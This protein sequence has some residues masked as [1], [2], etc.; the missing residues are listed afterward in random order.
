MNAPAAPSAPSRIRSARFRA[1]READWRRLEEIVTK[2]ERRG[3]R[4]LSF[5][6]AHD[7]ATLYRQAMTSLSLARAISLDRS[8]LAYLEALCARA[9][10]AVYAPQERLGGMLGRL[11]VHGI[12]GAVRRSVPIIL[13]G[14][15]ILICGG[16]A[17]FMLFQQD[18]TWYNTIVPPGLAQERGLNASREQLEAVITSGQ[19][20]ALG[21]L[22][23]F[24]SI[25]FSH[26]TRI[27]LFIFSLGVLACIPSAVLTFYNGLILGAFVALH[28]DRD[29]AYEITAWLSIHGITELSAI[30]I[31]CAGGFHLGL[32]VL[33]P[34]D[35]SRR[36]ALR[37]RSR[38]AVK[39]AILAAFMLIVAAVLEG[40]FRQLVQDPELRLTIGIG[41]GLAWLAYFTF[42]G[43][44]TG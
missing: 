5:D 15:L 42:S 1:E 11:I 19:D 36:H 33:F 40:Y 9:Y 6:E 30:V 23:A 44:R 20:E 10:L 14:F 13:L 37:A 4:A 31:A 17:G 12:P 8:L 35:L 26:N 39:L 18:P 25:L 16:A 32:A 2:A 22:T 34:G 7:M 3:I 27:A 21:G 29:L 24:A 41:V 43:R 28:A 38:D